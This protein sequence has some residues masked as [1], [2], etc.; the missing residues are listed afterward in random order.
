[1]NWLNGWCMAG[2]EGVFGEGL[3]Q[4]NAPHQSA[5]LKV[6]AGPKQTQHCEGLA[7]KAQSAVWK[8]NK[9][10]LWRNRFHVLAVATNFF[11]VLSLSEHHRMLEQWTYSYFD[12]ATTQLHILLN[13]HYYVIFIEDR[14]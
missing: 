13:N 6:L 8:Y 4:G 10:T 2:M 12:L 7:L 5:W 14:V 3:S 11:V 1:M 9:Q